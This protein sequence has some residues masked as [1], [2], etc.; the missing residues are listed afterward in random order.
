MK[1]PAE[2][3]MPLTSHL[4]ELRKR[5]IRILIIVGIGF[6]A[7]WYFREWLFQVIT[8]PLVKV[9]P[10]NSH[11][12]YTSL[13]EA[14]FNYMKISFYASLFLTSP[15]TL[16][17]LWKFI[18]PGLYQ[19]EKKYVAP[20]VISSSLLFT[21]GVLFGYYL[22][23][24]PAYSFFVEFSSDFLKPM[25]S[26]K[27]YLSLSLKLLLAFGLSFE[28]PVFIF[29]MAKIGIVN[30]KMLAKQRRYAILVIFI[31]AAVLTP[32]PDA[33]TQIIMAIPLMIL[34][35]F[36]IFIAKFAEKKRP[37]TDDVQEE[38]KNSEEETS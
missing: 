19:T 8:A 21:G 12:I 29:F 37:K 4:D 22:A 11:M 33:I 35:E 10:Q 30:S 36:S 23:L 7:C 15:F 27:E 34:Y 13:P 31:A 24:P 17:Q 6:V 25:F 14:F 1:N 18:S 16:Y 32:S 2:E 3:K 38:M 5:L 9:L 28:L 20:F 26:L